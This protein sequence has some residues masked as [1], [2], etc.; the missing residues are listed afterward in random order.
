MTMRRCLATLFILL[1]GCLSL[2]AQGDS[3]VVYP[4]RHGLEPGAVRRTLF[5][6]RLPENLPGK[7]V[8]LT[9]TLPA[10]SAIAGC[11]PGVLLSDSLDVRDPDDYKGRLPYR[12]VEVTGGYPTLSFETEPGAVAYIVTDVAEDVLP[13]SLLSAGLAS[14]RVGEKNLPIKAGN[15]YGHT[16]ERRVFS[17]YKPL[18]VPGDT[19]SKNFRIPAILKTKSGTLIAVADRR[20]FNQ[21]DIPEDIDIVIRRSFDNGKS[22]SGTQFVIEGYGHGHGYGDAALVQA[23][24]GKLV[25]VFIGG[26]GLWHSTPEKPMPTYVMTSD[27]DGATWSEARDITHF[28]YGKD[29]P[30]PVRSRFLSSFC[31]SGQGAVSATG[32]IMFA[33]AMRTTKEY[34]LD[35]YLIY[36]DDEGETWQVSD[37]AYKG[38]DESKVLPLPDGTILMSIRNPHRNDRIFRVS[39]D[40]GATWEEPGTDAYAGLHDPACN[41]TP[42]LVKHQGKSVLIHSLPKGPRARQD[43][44]IYHYDPT[45]QKWSEPYIVNPGMSAY[46]DMTLLDDETIGYF[47]E[48]DDQMTLT[49][50]ALPIADLFR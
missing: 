16:A 23:L 46:S 12:A 29:C 20:K 47:V 48:E 49:F 43:G 36:S 26:Q 45:T 10:H 42:L 18:F 8:E 30:D 17:V 39:R 24:S 31:A 6:L 38:G 33:A 3:V 40:N 41:G 35:N 7:T 2:Y 11:R 34:K 28:L 1:A 32:R 22:W 9:L 4:S 37:L 25:M 13:G 14:V 44:A 21:V 19:G 27:D 50:I 15:R 5:V